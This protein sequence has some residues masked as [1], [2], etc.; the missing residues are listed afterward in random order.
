MYTILLWEVHTC[1]VIDELWKNTDH[2]LAIP[3]RHSLVIMRALIYLVIAGPTS[4]YYSNTHFGRKNVAL[5]SYIHFNSKRRRV[6]LQ[7]CSFPNTYQY[8]WRHI[9]LINRWLWT[10]TVSGRT[11]LSADMN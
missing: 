6:Q 5:F 7:C 10:D 1:T 9:A 11:D 3:S 4:V 8:F 2:K